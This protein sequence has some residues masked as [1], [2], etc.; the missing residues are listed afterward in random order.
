MV[1]KIWYDWQ[2]ANELNQRAFEGG[3]VQ[4]ID[5]V[6]VYKKYSNGGPPNLHVSLPHCLHRHT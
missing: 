4:M 1:D 6:T 3:S 2:N 5:N